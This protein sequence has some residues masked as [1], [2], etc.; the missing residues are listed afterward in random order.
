[1][2]VMTA[3]LHRVNGRNRCA[4][5]GWHAAVRLSS[6]GS[7]AGRYRPETRSLAKHR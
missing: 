2:V 4:R 1:M 6:S 5:Q 3:A 7:M